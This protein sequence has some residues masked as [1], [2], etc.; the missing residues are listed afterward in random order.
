MYYSD[1]TFSQLRPLVKLI[2]ECCENPR[3]HHSAVFNKYSDKRF[4]RA[5]AFVESEVQ[6]GFRVPENHAPKAF[7]APPIQQFFDTVSY[8]HG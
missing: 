1:Y 8:F 2:L 3:K 4:K 7:T 6:R 5:S